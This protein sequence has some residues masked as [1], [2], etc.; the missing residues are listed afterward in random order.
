MNA[1]T[2][3]FLS[4]TMAAFVA[5]KDYDSIPEAM[6]RWAK[7]IVLDAIG[8]AYASTRF[9]FA[10][11]A[12][13][14]LSGLSSGNSTVIGMPVQLALRDAVLMNG[15][16]MHGLDYD[17]T[18]LPG[19][20]HLTGSCVPTALALAE[21]LQ[22][23]GREFLT[24]CAL[25]LEAGVRLGAAS[26]GGFLKLGF[27]PTSLIGTFA[28]AL[29]AGRLMQLSHKHLVMAQGVALSFASG[30]MQPTQEGAWA[31]RLH[32]GWA[33]AAG[34]TAASMARQ[35]FTGP[36]ETYEGRFGL[37]PCFL[38]PNAADADLS[39]ATHELGERWEFSRSSIKLY[40]VCYHSHAFM[41]AATELRNEKKLD[42]GQIESIHA[43][44]AEVAVPMICEPLEARRKPHN[45]YA[46]QFSL[47][48]AIACCLVRGRFGLE[49]IDESAY[50]DP[51]LLALA[52]KVSYE[53]DPKSGW[54]KY[55][56]GEIIVRMK[57]GQE[58]A[59]RK[60]ILPDEQAADKDIFDKF[61]DNTRF[62]LPPSQAKK[63]LEMIRNIERV[64]DIREVTRILAG[65]SIS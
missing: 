39:L 25:G 45:S 31:K 50:S 37:F 59:L 44:V 21:Q 11:K 27:H 36:L 42:I 38:G 26:K 9:E 13:S 6:R 23:S 24:A 35:G 64:P 22:A 17:D 19:G 12:L 43:L 34:I 49:E 15:T 1:R 16:L 14:S 54:P 33:G 4:E 47:P 62:S 2:A 53:I 61:M 40:P 57:N 58:I 18:Y 60:N 51:R 48:Y 28:S 5:G 3:P 65:R 41:R 55:R 52:Q 7:L 8:N 30:N 29:I 63:I 56:T 20:V 46:T 10:H 32:A